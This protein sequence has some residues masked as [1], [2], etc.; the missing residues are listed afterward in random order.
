MKPRRDTL[1]LVAAFS[2]SRL[3]FSSMTNLLC[4]REK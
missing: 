4:K 1:M 2:A 3:I